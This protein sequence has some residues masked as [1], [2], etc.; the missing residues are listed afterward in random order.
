MVTL[1][2]AEK[3]HILVFWLNFWTKERAVARTGIDTRLWSGTRLVTTSKQDPISQV[4][5]L[6]QWRVTSPGFGLRSRPD[7][8]SP[9][10]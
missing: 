6:T 1:L 7:P 2:P 10:N 3:S 8:G 5:R 9:I 4:N